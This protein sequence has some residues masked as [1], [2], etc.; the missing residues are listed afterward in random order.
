[1]VPAD[2]KLECETRVEIDRKLITAGWVVQ[3]DKRIN[4]YESLGVAVREN[5][6]DTGPSDYILYIDG[7]TCGVIEAKREGETLGQP[8]RIRY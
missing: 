3:G 2:T 1:M 7:K 8:I 4:L 5:R 6:T